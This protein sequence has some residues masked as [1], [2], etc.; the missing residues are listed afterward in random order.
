[1]TFIKQSQ[2]LK[3]KR[4]RMINAYDYI[5]IDVLSFLKNAYS[6]HFTHK[7][8]IRPTNR[9]KYEVSVYTGIIHEFY[10][11]LKQFKNRYTYGLLFVV[12]NNDELFELRCEHIFNILNMQIT[13]NKIRHFQSFVLT[14]Q[15]LLKYIA[16]IE[17]ELFQ[18]LEI[19]VV[20][21]NSIVPHFTNSL[22]VTDLGLLIRD[23]FCDNVL[24]KNRIFGKNEIDQS[25]VFAILAQSY[26]GRYHRKDIFP[27]LDNKLDIM[28]LDESK[29][30]TK[31]AEHL[32]SIRLMDIRI[33]ELPKFEL[34]LVKKQQFF[35]KV[36]NIN[37]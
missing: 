3:L 10:K 36:F 15:K 7:I 24:V 16:M 14:Y 20:D 31:L 18:V 25:L 21:S 33:T 6:K 9:A 32:L 28:K 17:S 29:F 1:M 8:D 2:K 13:K 30:D 37:A 23:N 26:K 5:V 11:L 4:H 27:L 12:H 34:P 35:R 19:S 22:L